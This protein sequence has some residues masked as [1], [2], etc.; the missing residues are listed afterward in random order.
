MADSWP[1]C[2]EYRPYTDDLIRLAPVKNLMRPRVGNVSAQ[3]ALAVKRLS[4]RHEE[5]L[6]PTCTCIVDTRRRYISVG[7]TS[8]SRIG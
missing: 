5:C 7:G 8:F 3:Y 4:F 2:E 6:S 1:P